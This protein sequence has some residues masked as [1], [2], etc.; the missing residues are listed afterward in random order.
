MWAFRLDNKIHHKRTNALRLFCLPLLLCLSSIT[1]TTAAEWVYTVQAGDNLWDLSKEHMENIGNWHKLQQLNNIADPRRVPPG[2]QIRFPLAWLKVKPAP[3]RVLELTGEVSATSS[4]TGAVISLKP[5]ATLVTGDEI[6]T[7]ANGNV[8]LEFLDGSR[9]LLQKN[10]L[11]IFEE[12]NTY[13]SSGV[14]DARVR[15]PRGRIETWVNPGQKK[16]TRFEIRTPAAITGVR[17]TELRVAMQEGQQVGRTEVIHGHVAVSGTVGKTIEVPAHFGTVVNAGRPPLT[18][19]PLLPPPDLSRLPDHIAHFQ[20]N[21]DWPAMDGA[22]FYRVQISNAT[23][24]ALLV[25]VGALPDPPLRAVELPDGDYLL[26]VRAVDADGLEGLNA[27]HRFVLVAAVEPPLLMTPPPNT[28]IREQQPVFHWESTAVAATFH[29]QLSTKRDFSAPL[30]DIPDHQGID[31]TL[32]QTLDPGDYF[33]RV[34]G[35]TPFGK[36]GLFSPVQQLSLQPE[37]ALAWGVLLYPLL[38]LLL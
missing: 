37:P 31:L 10:S 2:T 12:Q 38:L 1:T 16:G 3:V 26:R 19:K 30:I 14:L 28:T 23:A 35:R 34:A 13:S 4:Q 22:A 6:L 8:L 29:F 33:W 27:N 32:T 9:L 36:Q 21:F 25:D 17:G 7:G 24:S 11:L 5:G 18:P 20:V 15:L